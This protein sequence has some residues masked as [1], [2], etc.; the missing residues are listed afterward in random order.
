MN[1]QH[2]SAQSRVLTRRG[3]YCSFG[4]GLVIVVL[5][6]CGSSPERA[7]TPDDTGI[8]D[9]VPRV[10]PKAK[11]GN[12]DS[13]VVFGQRYHT[14]D[15]GRGHV[16]RGIASW[17]GKKFHGRK[18]SSGER[19]D[20]HQ[21][22]AAHKTL[23][24]P[25]YVM[26]TNLDNGRRAI[27]KVNDRGPFHGNRVIDLSFAAA[28]KLDVVRKGTARVEV[29]SIDPRDHGGKLPKNGLI[30]AAEPAAK[31]TKR[32]SEEARHRATPSA[33]RPKTTSP[34]LDSEK[35]ALAAAND[36]PKPRSRPEP[37]PWIAVGQSPTV[38]ARTPTPTRTTSRAGRTH[39][40]SAPLPS[41]SKG[42]LAT[43]APTP[44]QAASAP[45]KPRRSQTPTEPTPKAV[46]AEPVTAPTGPQITDA[47]APKATP[48]EVAASEQ[49]ARAPAKPAV[50]ANPSTPAVKAKPADGGVYLQVGAFGSKQNADQLRSRLLAQVSAPVQVRTASA[51]GGQ[52]YKVQ[53]GP[54]P[55]RDQAGDM[56][57]R[58]TALGLAKPMLVAQ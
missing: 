28:K 38:A 9:A 18:T 33:S 37:S 10:E 51:G 20:M 42:T 55:S 15:T 53:V 13:Y 41:A 44:T 14:K 49:P 29:R 1:R 4:V 54:L 39:I 30:T 21:M 26:V 17:Y 40:P 6:G 7:V 35:A 48:N 25:S 32:Q 47:P 52:L 56:T 50:A 12:M 11:L 46:A 34:W 57:R 2:P 23:P 27:V 31:P 19:Y 36:K 22:T 45:A 43:F 24:L 58:L 5:T 8:A 3:L 16:E